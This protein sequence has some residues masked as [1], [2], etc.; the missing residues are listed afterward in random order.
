MLAESFR[1]HAKLFRGH[2]FSGVHVGVD[3]D[4][5]NLLS[6]FLRFSRLISYKTMENRK[7]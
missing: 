7:C 6:L 4:M 1:L 5:W 2:E 3:V